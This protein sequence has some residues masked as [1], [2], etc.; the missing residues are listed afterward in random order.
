V[1][2][3]CGKRGGGGVCE[4]IHSTRGGFLDVI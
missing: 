4:Y 3:F 2:M 1:G